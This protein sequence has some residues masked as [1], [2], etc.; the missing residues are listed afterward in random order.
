MAAPL[1]FVLIAAWVGVSSLARVQRYV[2]QIAVDQ[3]RAIDLA[4]QIQTETGP[5]R[6]WELQHILSTAEGEMDDYRS[7]GGRLRNS[8]TPCKAPRR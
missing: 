4:T 2:R 7:R 3:M 1:A 6:Q 8:W 5:Y